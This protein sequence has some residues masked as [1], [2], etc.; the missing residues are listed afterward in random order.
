MREFT[1]CQSDCGAAVTK[2]VT[3]NMF[4]PWKLQAAYDQV[5]NAV[6][7]GWN[8]GDGNGLLEASDYTGSDAS[9]T[10]GWNICHRDLKEEGFFQKKC[11]STFIKTLRGEATSWT[12]ELCRRT[13]WW[14][15]WIA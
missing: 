11:V 14:P 1:G 6:L 4:D 9:P 15:T 13:L 10:A 2:R 7:Y 5:N 3:V 12:S 8:S